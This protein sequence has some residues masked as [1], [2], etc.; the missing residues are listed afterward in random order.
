MRY[1]HRFVF[2]LF[3]MLIATAICGGFEA[4][5]SAAAQPSPLGAK[6]SDF[7][8]Y[9]EL[10]GKTP[11]GFKGFEAFEL[12]TMK[13]R[14]SGSVPVKPYGSVHAGRKY[15]MARI[16][17]AGDRLSFETVDVGGVTYQFSGKL[18]QPYK[19]DGPT[20]SGLLTRTVNGN[21][22]AEAKV[23]FDIL[24]GVD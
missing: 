11:K 15:K 4:R 14:A 7:D 2:P 8:G 10:H 16:N 17:I 5:L 24:E 9:Y 13:Y 6:A 23:E 12:Y 21:K 22:A 3:I 19:P 20:L 1:I 18:L